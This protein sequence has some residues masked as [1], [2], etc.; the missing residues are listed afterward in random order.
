VSEFA[1]VFL[2]ELDSDLWIIAIAIG[3]IWLAYGLMTLMTTIWRK[4]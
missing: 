1:R 2:V 3:G 4:P